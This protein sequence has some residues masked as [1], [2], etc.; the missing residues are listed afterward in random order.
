MIYVAYL[1]LCDKTKFVPAACDRMKLMSLPFRF[2]LQ[3]LFHTGTMLRIRHVMV[4]SHTY[5]IHA[6]KILSTLYIVHILSQLQ[7]AIPLKCSS[8]GINNQC[9]FCHN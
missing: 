2:M 9:A 6:N 4:V 1:G 3:Y 5:S 7:G 8:N